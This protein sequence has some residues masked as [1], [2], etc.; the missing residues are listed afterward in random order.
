MRLAAA[1]ILTALL[2]VPAFAQAPPPPTDAAL[3][4]RMAREAELADQNRRSEL[5][6]VEV[7]RK[8]AE[9]EA[10]NAEKRTAYA[11]AEADH[12]AA[13][14]AVEAEA[15]RIAAD[16]AAA[17]AAYARAMAKWEADVAACKAGDRTKCAPGG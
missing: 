8:N 9:V 2:A 3:A 6:N 17:Q 5:L 13:V 4:A 11:K 10:R 1:L 12:Q 7:N 16:A 15:A 14:A